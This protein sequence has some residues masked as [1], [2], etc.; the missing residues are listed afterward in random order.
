MLHWAPPQ[1]LGGSGFDVVGYQVQV[2]YVFLK[3]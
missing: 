1:H 3:S 2:Q